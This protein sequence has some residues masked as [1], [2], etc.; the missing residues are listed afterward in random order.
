LAAIRAIYATGIAT[1]DAA[2]E[3]EPPGWTD[4]DAD[5]HPAVRFVAE[6]DG[7][8]LGW[9]AASPVAGLC[10]YGGVAEHSV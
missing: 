8:I 6:G 4:F 9:I 10:A 1:G 5:K 2:F 3:S 7:R